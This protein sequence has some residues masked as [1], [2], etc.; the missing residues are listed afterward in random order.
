M[1]TSNNTNHASY[2]Q[3]GLKKSL[4][5]DFEGADAD[6]SMALQGDPESG[7]YFLRRGTLRYKILKQYKDALADLIKAVEL[8][9][10]NPECYLHR[11][12]VR[13]HLLM[14][15]EALPDFDR[16]LEM[17]PYEERAYFNRGKL[18]FV[19]KYEKDEVVADLEMAIRLGAPQGAQMME[20]FYG[21]NGEV[22]EKV[23]RGI[24]ARKKG[25]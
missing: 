3:N 1:N 11:G 2:Y 13:C 20:M 24:D 5:R 7:I 18:K 15:P 17:N 8:A 19:L 22:G 10:H 6:Y 4:V 12:I 9:P 14:F 23:R 25:L 16:C 21:N